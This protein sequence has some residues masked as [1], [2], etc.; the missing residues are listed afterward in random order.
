MVKKTMLFVIVFIIIVTSA[1]FLLMRFYKDEYRIQKNL[2]SLASLVE[3][4]KDETVVMSLAKAQKIASF[5]LED[6][7]IGIGNPVPQ[8]RDKD[9]LISI[10][11]QLL[12]SVDNIGVKLTDISITLEDKTHAQSTFVVA[13]TVSSSLMDKNKIYPR[14]LE[15]MWEKIDR[16]WEISGVKVVEILH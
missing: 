12:Q 6:C 15:I 5:F 14:Q 1:I 11:S 2:N 8:I 3:K 10:S 7:Q 13:V 16:N 9:E 4:S